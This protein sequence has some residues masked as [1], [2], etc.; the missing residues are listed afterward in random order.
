[1]TKEQKAEEKY[2]L[3]QLCQS[4]RYAGRQDLLMAL[5]LPDKTYSISEAD[6][7]IQKFMKGKVD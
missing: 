5:L 2:T 4:K 7:L 1:M 6:T 3:Q